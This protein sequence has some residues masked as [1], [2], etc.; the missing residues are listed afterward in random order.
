MR[1]ASENSNAA[2]D[3]QRRGGFSLVELMVAVAIMAVVSI[4]ICQFTLATARTLFDSSAKLQINKDIRH[5]TGELSVSGRTAR[6]FYLYPSFPE[7]SALT[8]SQRRSAGQS[9]DLAIFMATE[10]EPIDEALPDAVQEFY[11]TR[12][13][14]YARVPDE[15]SQMGPVI[16]YERTY[17]HD[18]ENGVYAPRTSASTFSIESMINDMLTSAS[19]TRREVLQLSRGLADE[20][21]FFNYREH[22][23][24]VNGEILHGNDTRRV[25]NTYNFTVTPRG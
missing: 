24:I 25:T 2:T 18:P 5:F 3:L 14:A 12:L 4:G 8:L 16:R 11:V 9:G 22:S 10:P 20:R 15:G 21:L 1:Y 7:G 17:P 6:A 13:V 19:T 23:L